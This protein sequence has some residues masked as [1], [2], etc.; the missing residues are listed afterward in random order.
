MIA[1]TPCGSDFHQ[2]YFAI[3]HD[4]FVELLATGLACSATAH[5]SLAQK[6]FRMEPRGCSRRRTGHLC[7]LNSPVQQSQVPPAIPNPVFRA[8][9]SSI[10]LFRTCS[11]GVYSA[12]KAE[13][14]GSS[15]V[16]VMDNAWHIIDPQMSFFREKMSDV[17]HI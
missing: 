13:L 15:H 11:T 6:T 12:H 8:T 3:R 1:A 5:P 9:V 2:I 10:D 7:M 17:S 4:M 14:L 16:I